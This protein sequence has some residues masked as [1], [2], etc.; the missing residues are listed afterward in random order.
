MINWDVSPEI[1]SLGPIHVRWYG[2]L[3]AA[4]FLIGFQI[5]H[6]IFIKENKSENDLNDLLWYML[7]G[8]ILGARLGHCL[9]YSPEYYLS[10][11]LEILK[12]WKGGLASHGAAIGITIAIRMYSKKKI[13][14]P[15]LWVYD[16]VVITVALAGFFIRTGNLMNSEIIGIPTDVPWAFKFVRAYVTD[17]MTPRH[18][19]QL[20]EAL[21]YLT[22]FIVLYFIYYKSY[23]KIKDGL[24]FGIFLV[25]VFTARFFIEFIKEDQS[26]FE[27][28]MALNMG[29]ILSIP[30]IIWGIYLILRKDISNKVTT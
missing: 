9:F 3:F 11:P 10:N 30:L 8:T 7:A 1:F 6:K 13:G 25:S 24:I 14:Q 21:S 20:Y 27:A 26:A 28:G 19:A 23:K 4:S 18:P 17:P 2:L 29:Q 5:M 15:F 12:V 16:R 22:I